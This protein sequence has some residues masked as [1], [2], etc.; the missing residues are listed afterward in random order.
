M[1]AWFVV[2]V[3]VW[4][5]LHVG[6]SVKLVRVSLGIVTSF[7]STFVL[8]GSVTIPGNTCPSGPRCVLSS[9]CVWATVSGVIRCW[10]DS[11]VGCSRAARAPPAAYQGIC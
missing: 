6:V 10:G 8:G 4:A 3:L 5:F 1:G 9:H 7:W 2:L 11:V